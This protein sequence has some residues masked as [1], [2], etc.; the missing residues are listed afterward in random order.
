MAK[1]INHVQY[2]DTIAVTECTDG[3]WLYDKTRGMNL[4]MHV[5][6]K[7]DAFIEALTY[8]QKRLTQNE[9]ELATLKSKVEGFV[10]QFIVEHHENINGDYVTMLEVQI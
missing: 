2:T 7:D 6:T 4:S 9:N 3:F 5:K 8:Y 1:T 10:N